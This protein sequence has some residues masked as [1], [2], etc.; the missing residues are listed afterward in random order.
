MVI[1]SNVAT[2]LVDLPHMVLLLKNREMPRAI[3]VFIL[4]VCI[5]II[6]AYKNRFETCKGS[7]SRRSFAIVL[8]PFVVTFLRL[9]DKRGRI[10][11]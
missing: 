10:L 11:R 4:T 3:Y 1:A 8:L 2:S 5:F 7:P 9:L 6:F